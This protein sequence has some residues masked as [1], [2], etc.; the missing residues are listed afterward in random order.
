MT[1]DSLEVL[2]NDRRIAELT[3][4]EIAYMAA[5]AGAPE[6]LARDAATEA[7]DHFHEVWARE[8]THLPISKDLEAEVERLLRA[9]PLAGGR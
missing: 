5:K 6:A 8:R 9:V 2:L 4:D 1:A 3:M 7:V